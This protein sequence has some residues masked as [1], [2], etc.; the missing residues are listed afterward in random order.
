VGAEIVHR[1][2]GWTGRKDRDEVAID[3]VVH[4]DDGSSESVTLRNL[5]TEGCR[6]ESDNDFR[7]GEYLQIAIPSLGQLNAQVRWA[8]PGSAGARFLAQAGA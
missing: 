2:H 4:R 5:S 6:I 7:I 1:I 3:A 8:L